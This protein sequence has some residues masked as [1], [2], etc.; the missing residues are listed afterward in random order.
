MRFT[1]LGSGSS[2]NALVVE[3][4]RTRVMMDCGFGI[5]ETCERL[6]RVGLEP[7]DLAAI[8]VTHE[9]DDHIGGV[10]RFAMKHAI[11]IYLTRGTAQWLPP[12]FPAVLVNFIDG[13]VFTQS[14]MSDEQDNIQS[15]RKPS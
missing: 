4:G 8:V 13:F 14:E 15:K 10:A 6:G 5:A 9:H 12:N 3:C 2:G 7:G 1:S 11:P